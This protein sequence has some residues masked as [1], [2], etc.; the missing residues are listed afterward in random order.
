M[1]PSRV[2]GEPETGDTL[3]SH[4][5]NLL[6]LDAGAAAWLPGPSSRTAPCNVDPGT[7]ACMLEDIR[8]FMQ[9]GQRGMGSKTSIP[10]INSNRPDSFVHLAKQRGP[11]VATSVQLSIKTPTIIVTMQD[12]SLFNGRKWLPLLSDRSQIPS[13]LQ[14]TPTSL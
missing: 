14:L 12:H 13:V 10:G 2:C 4:H 1:N 6:P 5:P 11:R 9:W 8:V 3:A 7:D